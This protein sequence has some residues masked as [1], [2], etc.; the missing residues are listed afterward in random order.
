LN[1]GSIINSIT[2]DSDK[3]E[4][5]IRY[6]SSSDPEHKE[7]EVRV[8]VSDL[9]NPWIV[10]EGHEGAILLHKELSGGTDGADVLHAEVVIAPYS[11]STADN[12]IENIRGAL[13]VKDRGND[14]D[15]VKNEAKVFEKAVIGHTID[16]ECGSD[17]RYE[18][19]AMATY[20]NTADSFNNADVILDANL[21]RVEDKVDSVSSE[22]VCVDAKANKLYEL[23]VGVGSSMQGCGETAQYTPDIGSCVISAAT[24]FMEA[25]RM[26]GDQICEILEMWVSGE[27]CTT[28]SD[29]VDDG[30]NKKMLVDVKLSRGN[31]GT[32]TDDEIVIDNLTGD[33]IDP[34]NKEFTDT[35]ALRIVCLT[36]GGSVTPAISTPQNGIYLSNV[37]DCGLYYDTNN[38]EDREAMDKANAAGYNTNYLSEDQE[39]HYDYNNNVR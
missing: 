38:A 32:M 6:T 21:K 30:A 9:F 29:W 14:I 11:G 16:E 37:W 28:K 35:N 15:C 5:V 36:D 10:Q 31:D 24:S 1:A 13:Y 34:T 27:T 23:L 12:A 17:Y 7:L 4:L 26:L 8:S 19:N 18:P 2:Y 39:S 22:T 25:D 33:Y 3:K 20:I